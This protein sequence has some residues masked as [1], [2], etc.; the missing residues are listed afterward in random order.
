MDAAISNHPIG[1]RSDPFA[2]PD[3]RWQRACQAPEQ[4]RLRRH[5]RQSDPDWLQ[6]L[7]ALCETVNA[8]GRKQPSQPVPQE[9]LAAYRLFDNG[10]PLRWEVEARI[11]AG[12]SDDEIAA[13]TGMA[14]GAV[15]QFER[16]FF[17]VRNRLSAVDLV[18]LEIIG[19][20]PCG[21]IRP[22]DLRTLWHI[23]GYSAGPKMLEIVMAVSQD[24]PMPAWVVE[25]APSPSAL[26]D[27]VRGT[28][29][30][31]WATSAPLRS[32]DY[33]KWLRL[34]TQLLEWRQSRRRKEGQAITPGLGV[35]E[36]LPVEGLSDS[37]LRPSSPEPMPGPSETAAVA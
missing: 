6:P 7:L 32:K 20:H 2:P 24:R 22:G 34:Q 30:S 14:A 12:Q 26:D 4:G 28:K 36:S 27:L 3:W 1:S 15:S 8:T 18:L 37:A 21:G 10:G 35:L 23:W 17:D 5:K 29:L 16:S 33:P 11:L 13:A 25:S 31:I 19:F 9:L